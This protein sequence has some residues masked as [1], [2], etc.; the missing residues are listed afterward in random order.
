MDLSHL[1]VILDEVALNAV[2]D[3]FCEV[4]H[5]RLADINPVTL[6]FLFE[7]PCPVEM[8]LWSG[9]KKLALKTTLLAMNNW[10]TC[11]NRL[12]FFTAFLIL[13]ALWRRDCKCGTWLRV[14][15]G[16]KADLALFWVLAWLWALHE[17]R[18]TMIPLTPVHCL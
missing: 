9:K 12:A 15:L 3:K 11:I 1:T 6:V 5:V 7:F 16:G 4:I 17:W 8:I 2:K 13:F 10:G 14:I 18:M